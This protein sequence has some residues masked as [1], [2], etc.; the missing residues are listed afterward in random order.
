LRVGIIG[1]GAI[2]AK[3][4]LA[5]N[6]IGFNI[7]ACTNATAARGKRFA[8]AHGAEYVGTAEE[9][10]RHPQ[11]DYVDLCTLPN[12]RLP[13]VELCAQNGKH[14]LVQKPMATDLPTAARMMAVAQAAKIQLG[15][16]SQHRF[17][18]SI[19]FLKKA[20][21]DGR[22]GRI[23]QADA[24]VKW[25]RSAE[26][27][28]RPVKGSWAGEGGGALINQGIHQ[29]D[30]LLYLAG[31]VTEVAACWQLGAVHAIESEDSVSALL[32]YSSGATGVLQASTAIWPGYPERIEIHGT[33]GTAVVTGDQLTAW[34]VRDDTGEAPP[35]TEAAKSGASDPMAVSVVPFERQMLD[36]A[37][38]C[39]TGRPPLCSAQEGYRALTLVSAIYESCRMEQLVRVS[40]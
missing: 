35:L 36:F 4:A 3:H 24:Y 15:V 17:D 14:L 40:G 8:E 6:N 26:Y 30:L 21:D 11:V 31:P 39:R 33:K 10:C 34:D 5:Y 29:V 13:V 20:I 27:Y 25:Y 28:A 23:L 19:Q 2:S 7:V 16:V 12:F 37:Q 9:L 38:A 18:D 32:K 22:L 1:T